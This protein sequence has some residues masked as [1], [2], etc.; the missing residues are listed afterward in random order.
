MGKAVEEIAIRQNHKVVLKIDDLNIE[1]FTKENLKTA[2]VAIEFS[3]PNSAFNNIK[4]CLDYGIPVVSGTTGWLDKFDLIKQIC[5]EKK[6][7]FF[8]AP[9]F[10]IAVNILFQLNENLS[11]IMNDFPDYE[12]SIDETHHIHK[13]DAPSGT[14][15]N[16]AQ[17]IIKNIDRKTDWIRETQSESSQIAIRSH[18][19]GEHTG[20]HVIKYQTDIDTIELKHSSTSRQG[21]A[22]GAV[23]AAK[24]IIG[25]KGIFGMKD[26]LRSN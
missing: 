5:N 16:I 11:K 21:L 20:E 8:Y 1:E 15:I 22:E 18:R 7:A 10:S 25:K 14:A 4:K 6:G 19:E 9:N 23:T 24:F 3:T 26:L 13:L 17:D 2:D 12:V